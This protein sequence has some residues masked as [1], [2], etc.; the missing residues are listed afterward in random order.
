[1]YEVFLEALC[2]ALCGAE[3]WQNVEFQD[4]FSPWVISKNSPAIL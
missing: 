3:G 1:M 2:A 4:L